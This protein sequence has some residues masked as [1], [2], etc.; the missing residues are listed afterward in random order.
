VQYA[1]SETFKTHCL[2]EIQIRFVFYPAALRA[3]QS[4]GYFIYSVSVRHPCDVT[5]LNVKPHAAGFA[6]AR[7]CLQFLVYSC[8]VF[9]F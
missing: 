8:Y 2:P 4:A 6:A 3:A 9:S 1:I 7:R 5:V